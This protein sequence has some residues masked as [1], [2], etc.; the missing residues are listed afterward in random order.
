MHPLSAVLSCLPSFLQ[1]S[2]WLV[3]PRG[4]CVPQFCFVVSLRLFGTCNSAVGSRVT[5][6]LQCCCFLVF[7]FVT[8]IGSSTCHL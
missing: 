5:F 1:H 3:D 6:A 4:F 8:V 2:L 7:A